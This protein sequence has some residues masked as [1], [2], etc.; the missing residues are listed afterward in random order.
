MSMC[1]ALRSLL[2]TEQPLIMPDAYDAASARLIELSGFR[3]VQCSGF[4]MAL[5]SCA[6]AEPKLGF[7]EMLDITRR[8][9]AAVNVPVMADGE[10]GFGGP[11]R[12]VDVVAAYADAGV[13]GI[14]LED[15]LLRVSETKGIIDPELMA[16]KL[17]AAREGAL[18]QGSADLVLNARTDALA[19]MPERT[20]GLRESVS[21]GNRYFE[22]GADLV[23]VTGVKTAEEAR[24][25]VQEING[26]ISVAAGLVYNINDVSIKELRACGVARISLPTIAVLSAFAAIR[27]TLSVVRETEE[28]ATLTQEGRVAGMDMVNQVLS[29]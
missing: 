10:D 22:A 13:A 21:R 1:Q 29:R 18:H 9:V 2:E 27:H 8:I 5:A 25:L 28:F 3:A 23:F 17:R 4:S 6:V 11:D 26:P 7:E 15:Q 24:L 12:V 16:E 20:A 14:N 19:T